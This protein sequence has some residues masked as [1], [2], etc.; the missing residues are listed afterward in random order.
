MSFDSSQPNCNNLSFEECREDH[1]GTRFGDLCGNCSERAGRHSVK[2]P[3]PGLNLDACVEFV[4]TPFPIERFLSELD[5]LDELL[6]CDRGNSP[7]I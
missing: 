1:F 6:N 4:P 7:S 5:E 3:H 2:H